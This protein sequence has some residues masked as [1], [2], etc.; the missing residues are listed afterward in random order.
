MP[1]IISNTHRV[2]ADGYGIHM[3]NDDEA[4][5]NF[6]SRHGG[7]VL[8]AHGRAGRPVDTADSVSSKSAS[9]S[10]PRRDLTTKPVH[11]RAN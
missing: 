3:V 10:R 2:N 8:L 1:S 7:C 5:R 11:A 6:R 9:R 4:R